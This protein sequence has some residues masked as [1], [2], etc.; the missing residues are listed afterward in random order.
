MTTTRYTQAIPYMPHLLE[1][2][3]V[4]SDDEI[5]MMDIH[6]KLLEEGFQVDC[7]ITPETITLRATRILYR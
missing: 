7:S 4:S 3:I 5:E 6:S 2:V 1:T